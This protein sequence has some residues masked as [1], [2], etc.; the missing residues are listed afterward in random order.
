MLIN[1]SIDNIHS[2]RYFPCY[3][4]NRTIKIY[5]YHTLFVYSKQLSSSIVLMHI[6]GEVKIF[7]YQLN[8]RSYHGQVIESQNYLKLSFA[9]VF[10]GSRSNKL[11][12]LKNQSIN[13]HAKFHFNR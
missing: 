5:A 7:P 10:A 12:F 11:A 9:R 2:S 6:F 13:H 4:G 3:Q 8:L 1:I